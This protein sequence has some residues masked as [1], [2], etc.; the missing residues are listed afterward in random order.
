[1]SFSRAGQGRYSYCQPE[2][3]LGLIPFRGIEMEKAFCGTAS[4]FLCYGRYLPPRQWS[5]LVLVLLEPVHVA[6][7]AD[8]LEH[9]GGVLLEASSTAQRP[10][11]RARVESV[12]PSVVST[13]HVRPPQHR[14]R[15]RP[16]R[17]A[18]RHRRTTRADA[19]ARGTADAETGEA[20]RRGRDHRRRGAGAG[21]G[22]GPDRRWQAE[23]DRGRGDRRAGAEHLPEEATSD[24]PERRAERPADRGADDRR[25]VGEHLAGDTDDALP[26]VA[27]EVEETR[28]ATSRGSIEVPRLAVVI[29]SVNRRAVVAHHR[30]RFRSFFT[31]RRMCRA[32]AAQ[33]SQGVATS[34]T[35]VQW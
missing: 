10:R 21:R 32:H 2:S 14:H 23:R 7:L 31:I 9:L 15:E 27:D 6:L 20:R 1:M 22:R 30:L 12:H 13:R 28:V 5:A 8:E 26:D 11:Q 34:P 29:P 19:H 18:T 17:S 24:A 3:T 33:C 16:G 35:L 4:S 25:G